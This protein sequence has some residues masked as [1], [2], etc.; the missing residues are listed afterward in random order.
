LVSVEK[1][2][3]SAAL[4]IYVQVLYVLGLSEDITEVA[5]DDKL[6]KKLQDSKV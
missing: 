4:G 3:P 1:G 2:L 5:E 6:G